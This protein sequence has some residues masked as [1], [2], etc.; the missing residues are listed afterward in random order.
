MKPR[1]HKLIGGKREKDAG[2]PSAS[3]DSPTS[4]NKGVN[5]DNGVRDGSPYQMAENVIVLASTSTHVGDMTSS[6]KNAKGEDDGKKK[7]ACQEDLQ[8][9]VAIC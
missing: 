9:Q 5:V 4:P 3:N 1:K 8:I 2:T 6:K 7:K